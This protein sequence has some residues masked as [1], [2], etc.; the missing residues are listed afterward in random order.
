MCMYCK[1]IRNDK[2]YW[3][4]VETYISRHTQSQLSYGVCPKCYE[5]VLKP[6]L[7]GTKFPEPPGA[8]S[9][10]SKTA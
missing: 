4:T 6:E 1:S 9:S 10:V 8:E 7:Y 5:T 3:Q 2:N